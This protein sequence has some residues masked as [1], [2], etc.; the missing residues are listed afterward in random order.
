MEL[1]K[2]KF[3][4]FQQNFGKLVS[5]LKNYYESSEEVLKHGK[6]TGRCGKCMRFLSYAD[7]L[8][9]ITCTIC[10]DWVFEFPQTV[11]QMTNDLCPIDKYPIMRYKLMLGLNE[12]QQKD[13]QNRALPN[14]HELVNK[15]QNFGVFVKCCSYCGFLKQSKSLEY[16]GCPSLQRQCKQCGSATY[17]AE[18]KA[19]EALYQVC[20]NKHCHSLILLE[21]NLKD[22]RVTETVCE[23]CK[24]N[25]VQLSYKEKESVTTCFCKKDF[26]YEDL[27]IFA[28]FKA[29]G[30]RGRKRY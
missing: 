3:V 16:F 5:N 6:N 4:Y 9:K 1:F 2:Q 30:G 24:E 23:E 29:K 11:V 12:E 21:D 10:K 26:K 8:K 20:S 18:D 27:G 22:Y 13:I 7:Q 15:S 14:R 19:H 25:Q 17:Y 28:N